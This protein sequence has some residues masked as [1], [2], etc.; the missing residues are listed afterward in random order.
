[1][2][3]KVSFI[4]P[5]LNEE[6]KIEKCLSAINNQNYPKD[7]IEILIFDNGCTDKTIEISKKFNC[8]IINFKNQGLH[9]CHT[10]ALDY[11]DSE[12]FVI[13]A[14]DNILTSKEWLNCMLNPFMCNEIDFVF[15]DILVNKYDNLINK[16]YSYLHVEP[17]TWF[18][19]GKNYVRPS[20]F[21]KVFKST[22][23]SE[24]IRLFFNE[25]NHPLV[26]LA[27]GSCISRKCLSYLNKEKNFEDDIIPFI[28]IIKEGFGF[29]YVETGIYHEHLNGL[30]DFI[31]KYNKRIEMNL[32]SKKVGI[33]NRSRSLNSLRKF[34]MIFFPIY[35]LTI[36][37][38]ILDTFLMLNRKNYNYIFIHPIV[39]FVLSFNLIVRVIRKLIIK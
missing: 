31:N 25:K 7:K 32:N 12:V 10:K 26:A 4:L 37:L 35:G 21:K 3:P 8:S 30:S 14:A 6:N 16:Y 5:V 33:K 17:F 18:V 39:S 13:F 28:S 19:Y 38:P 36:V 1:M 9:E 11:S 29:A 23:H 22:E 27:Q 15:T 20:L 34:R 2:L 24:Y